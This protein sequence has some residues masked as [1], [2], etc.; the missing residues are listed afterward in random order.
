MAATTTAPRRFIFPLT[1]G[2]SGTVFLANALRAN[3]P[4]SAKVHHERIGYTKFGLDTPDL[5]TFT[6]F[7][8]VGNVP[9]VRE[10]WQRKSARILAETDGDYAE[11]S[12]FLMKAGLVENLDLL[13]AHGEVHLIVLTRDLHKTTLSIK[14]R[15]DFANSLLLW[16][17][18]LD[19]KYPR[20]IIDP[21]PLRRHGMTGAIIWYVLEVRARS[22]YYAMLTEADCRIHIHRVDLSEIVHP[23]GLA[24]LIT[25]LG[26]AI[27][28][29]TVI[30]PHRANATKRKIKF[31]PE[32]D[33]KTQT[34]TTQFGATDCV[35]VAR[36]Y[37]DAGLRLGTP[38]DHPD[39]RSDIPK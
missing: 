15:F 4:E 6:L 18:Y 39:S 35:G 37:F 33:Q 31:G 38:V 19:P 3:L 9:R 16:A 8:S 12:H 2:R 32:D 34:L 23:G 25:A 29:N 21:G 20:K 30:V 10:F 1:T 26:W 7:N 14:N 5:S 28:R 24:A 17:A 22:E 36:R 27:D 11:I 13:T